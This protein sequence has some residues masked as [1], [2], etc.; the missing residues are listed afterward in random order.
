M[1]KLPKPLTKSVLIPLR[2][3]QSASTTDS[4]IQKN[5]FGS[6]MTTL[7]ISKEEMNDIMK[8]IKSLEDADL[9][10]KRVSKTNE[11]EAKSQKDGILRMLLGTLSASLLGNL[12]AGRGVIRAGESTIRAGEGRIRA[13]KDF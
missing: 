4:A 7:R 9:L 11:N 6:G 12:S 1:K 2:L 8:I 5:I 10:K 3:T 13:V